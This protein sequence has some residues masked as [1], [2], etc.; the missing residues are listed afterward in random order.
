[1]ATAKA[2]SATGSTLQKSVTVGVKE[3]TLEAANAA[4]DVV[5]APKDTTFSII[6]APVVNADE[7]EEFYPYNITFSWSEE[8]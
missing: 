8:V 7:N 3:S 4:A 2:K 6:N 5:G 1:M